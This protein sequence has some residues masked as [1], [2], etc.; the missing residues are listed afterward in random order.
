MPTPLGQMVIEPEQVRFF[1]VDG[2]VLSMTTAWQIHPSFPGR[3]AR[4]VL[5]AHRNR[6]GFGLNA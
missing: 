5:T 1:E 3:V 2:G 6:D 4:G